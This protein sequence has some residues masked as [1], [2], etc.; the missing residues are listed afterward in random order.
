MGAE[1]KKGSGYYFIKKYQA[2]TIVS[3]PSPNTVSG[4]WGI[5]QLEGG[6]VDG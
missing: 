1:Y 4:V 5:T 2:A 3:V 6:G